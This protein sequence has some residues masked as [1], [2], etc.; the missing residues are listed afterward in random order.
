MSKANLSALAS[1][2]SIGLLT[3]FFMAVQARLRAPEQR[4][5]AADQPH[6]IVILHTNDIHGHLHSWQGWDQDLAGQTVGGLDRLATR[7]RDE[8]GADR[9]L[10]L[11]A[12]DTIGD[13]MVAVETQ[14]RAVIATLNA[15]RYDAMV[16]GNHEPDFT[17]EKLRARIAEARFPVLAANIINRKDGSLFTQPYL[18]REV[19]GVRVG[20]LGIAYPNTPLTSTQQNVA[21]LQFRQAIETAR[22]YVPRIKR[23]GADILIAL[24]HLGLGADKE[25]AEKVSGIDVIVGGHSHNRLKEAVQVGNTLIVQAGA[26]GSDLG[27]LDLTIANGRLLAHRSTLLPITNVASDATV[28]A[29]IKAQSKP[30]EA[31]LSESIG[32]AANWI[33]RPQTLAG[34][35]PEARNAESPADDLFADAIRE[36]TQAEIAFL[37]GVGYGVALQPGEITAAHLRNLLPHDAAVWTMKLTGAQIREV[38]EQAIENFTTKE[39]S[40]KVG[41]MIQ[42]SG[43]TFSYDPYEPRGHRVQHIKV[44]DHP[45]S[46]Q[47]RYAIAVNSLLAEGGH[48]FMAFTRGKARQPVGKQYEMVKA[49]IARRGEVSAPPTNRIIRLTAQQS[50]T[51]AHRRGR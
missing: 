16:I 37:P 39:P 44:G 18:I 12:G 47:Q 17:P 41:G 15:L 6:H 42:V 32:R 40:Q 48:H 45:L 19:N 8:V 10:L 46:T 22:E 33:V 11:D 29:L 24:T 51:Q 27:R 3:G 9:V 38:L 31:A 7:V 5:T 2:C 14:G 50:D 34:Q 43:L 36:T 1:F 20:I 23:E 13:S 4:L 25:L 21:G 28:A 35:K 26:H 30:Y 49:W